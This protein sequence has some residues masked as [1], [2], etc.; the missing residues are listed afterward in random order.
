[1]QPDTS[2]NTGRSDLPPGP[3]DLEGRASME[4]PR[5]DILPRLG[6][7]FMLRRLAADDVAA[8]Q[9]YRHDPELARYQGWS[10]M[11]DEEARAFLVAMTGAALLDPGSWTQI[12]IAEPASRRLIGDIGVCLA[13][14][15][16]CAEIGFTLARHAQGRGVATEAVRAAIG[17]I[18][19][20]SGTVDR[21]IAVT[22]ARNHA[23][24]RLLERVGMQRSQTRDAV[25][26]GEPCVEHVYAVARG[27]GRPTARGNPSPSP[28][29]ER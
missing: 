4:A 9:A 28:R 19:D 6:S 11:S 13:P 7:R 14:D 5:V 10:P 26:R 27:D 1:M 20:S 2:G 29:L 17:L 16:R 22:D 23:S 21:V 8:F 15:G 3:H 18:F 24:V 25:F 12:G